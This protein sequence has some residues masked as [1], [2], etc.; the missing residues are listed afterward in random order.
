MT[1]LYSVAPCREVAGSRRHK[2][3][4]L[5]EILYIDLVTSC[6]ISTFRLVYFPCTAGLTQGSDPVIL[7]RAAHEPAGF[8]NDITSRRILGAS[9]L[10]HLHGTSLG[11]V[12]VPRST[13]RRRCTCAPCMDQV[14]PRRPGLERGPSTSA[15]IVYP[16]LCA[17]CSVLYLVV[18]LQ[19]W[20]D[21]TGCDACLSLGIRG[22]EPLGGARPSAVCAEVPEKP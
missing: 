12:A 1:S 9:S 13:H 14:L 11:T 20:I 6:M 10:I 22:E 19:R 17:L 3:F 7:R 16:V 15:E 18:W 8:L 5:V 21:R 2:V 4:S